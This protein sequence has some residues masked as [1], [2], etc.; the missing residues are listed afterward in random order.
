MEFLKILQ[1]VFSAGLIVSLGTYIYY[2]YLRYRNKAN[3]D[4]QLWIAVAAGLLLNIAH[5]VNGMILG[6]YTWAQVSIGVVVSAALFVMAL[7]MIYKKHFAPAKPAAK[8]KDAKKLAKGNKEKPTK[9]KK[10]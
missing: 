5:Q 1:Y 4:F 10:K 7:W 6:S 9:G 3:V 2:L 8:A